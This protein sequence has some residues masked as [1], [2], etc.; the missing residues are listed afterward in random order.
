MG[1]R[2][3][4][5]GERESYYHCSSPDKLEVG[6]VY[7][8]ISEKV[9]EFHTEY[10]LKG[11]EGEFN[12]VWFDD[13]P[14]DRIFISHSNNTPVVGEKFTLYK[15][16]VISGKPYFQRWPTN[17]TVKAVEYIGGN[18]YKVNTNSSTYIVYVG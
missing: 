17:I 7:E 2:V 15:L 9:S 8:V 12:S 14:E 10:T 6:K 5:N 3:R 1:K 18:I 4:Y 16:I 13:I 11:V